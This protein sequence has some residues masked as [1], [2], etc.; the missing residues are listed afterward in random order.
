MDLDRATLERI[1]DYAIER[2]VRV[3]LYPTGFIMSKQGSNAF[4]QPVSV[5]RLVVFEEPLN[6][7]FKV[8]DEVQ[9]EFEDSA[10]AQTRHTRRA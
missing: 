3:R 7:A 4:F 8:I 10:H 1:A 5:E 9:A 2:A 6:H